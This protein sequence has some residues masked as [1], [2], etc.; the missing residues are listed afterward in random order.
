MWLPERIW[1]VCVLVFSFCPCCAFEVSMKWSSFLN[2][3][4][5]MGLTVAVW[6]LELRHPFTISDHANCRH[7]AR[8]SNTS[9]RKEN[10][11][12]RLRA[13]NVWLK[14]S[15]FMTLVFEYMGQWPRCGLWPQLTLDARQDQEREPS[16]KSI[17]AKLACHTVHVH[18]V[19]RQWCQTLSNCMTKERLCQPKGVRSRIEENER[20]GGIAG[21]QQIV[22][23]KR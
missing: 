3:W 15:R 17:G 9:Q 21:A 18:K 19:H 16:A 10:R 23:D 22:V 13:K 1:Y 2:W 5:L 7:D 12:D 4:T 14:S 11:Y 20:P 8:G 6:T